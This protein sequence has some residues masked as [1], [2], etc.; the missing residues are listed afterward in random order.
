MLMNGKQDSSELFPMNLNGSYRSW[1]FNCFIS[2]YHKILLV[3]IKTCILA[4]TG[5]V[6]FIEQDKIDRE[7]YFQKFRSIHLNGIGS[8]KNSISL[9]PDYPKFHSVMC[10]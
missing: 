8:V 2:F 1:P 9:M 7:R 6:F 5:T 10:P 3:L 4:W